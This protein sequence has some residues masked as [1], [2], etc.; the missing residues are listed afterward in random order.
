MDA[1]EYFLDVESHF[2]FGE[3]WRSFARLID[4]ERLKASD[5]GIGRLFEPQELLG[6]TVLDIGSG[7]GLPAASLVRKGAI[8]VTCVDID[9]NSVAATRQTLSG[10]APNNAW[11]A[12][13]ASV[14]SLVGPY[15]VVYSWGVLHHAGD[16]RRAVRHAASLV[17]PD[18]LLV[19]A[20]YAKTP[21]R[22]FWR[23]FKRIYSIAPSSVQYVARAV[24]GVLVGTLR[25]VTGR[26]SPSQ[27]RARRMNPDHD[28]HDWL[29]GFPYE[30]AS[31]ADVKAMLPEFG[32]VRMNRRYDPRILAYLDLAVTNTSCARR[33]IWPARS[34]TG[35]KS[36]PD[37]AQGRG[38]ITTPMALTRIEGPEGA[39]HPERRWP[40]GRRLPG[41]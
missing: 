23:V 40:K 36:R 41:H 9:E 14:F 33:A 31:L 1:I 18:G 17:K 34:L 3:N 8:H 22:G 10:F 28:I 15:D 5:A 30:S 27:I 2:A 16:M 35:E 24:Y 20:L 6:R 38:R 11:T 39:G 21:L 12:E 37:L 19:I 4:P 25:S 32:L 29:G 26:K 7:S 13:V